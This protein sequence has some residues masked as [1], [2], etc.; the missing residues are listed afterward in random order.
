MLI[1]KL[2]LHKEM[3]CSTFEWVNTWHQLICC[4]KGSNQKPVSIKIFVANMVKAENSPYLS[5]ICLLI[6]YLANIHHLSLSQVYDSLIVAFAV[7]GI[8]V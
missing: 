6:I 5:I 4:R 8:F 3:L 1:F 7:N 2:I